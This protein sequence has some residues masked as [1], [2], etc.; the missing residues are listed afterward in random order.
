MIWLCPPEA[1]IYR[2]VAVCS[3]EPAP[4]GPDLQQIDTHVDLVDWRGNRRFIGPDVM[5]E[6]LTICLAGRRTGPGDVNEPIGI[7]FHHRMM[8]ESDWRDFAVVCAKMMAHSAVNMVGFARVA[9]NTGAT[10]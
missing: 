6:R 7:L 3:A 2:A 5:A 4:A 8:G 9:D 1:G 10:S